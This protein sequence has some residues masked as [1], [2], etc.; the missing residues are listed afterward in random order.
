MTPPGI[1]DYFTGRRLVD[2]GRTALRGRAWGG[3]APVRRVEVGVDGIWAEAT[4]EPPLGEWAWRGRLLA[5]GDVPGAHARARRRTPA[6]GA[7]HAPP[8]PPHTPRQG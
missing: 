8:P 5:G 4:L 3:R 6:D 2:P 7:R 1:P